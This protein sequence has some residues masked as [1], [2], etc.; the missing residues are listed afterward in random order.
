MM[1]DLLA[2][3]LLALLCFAFWQQR[4]QAEL[5]R[6]AISQ[7]CRSLDLQLISVAFGAHRFKTPKGQ[8]RWHTIYRF[9]FSALGDD[10]YQ[11]EMTMVGFHAIAFDLPPHR[12]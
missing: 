3:L 4:R 12:I 8:W 5:A 11:G 10:C 9:E 7:K 1:G 2:I 6:A